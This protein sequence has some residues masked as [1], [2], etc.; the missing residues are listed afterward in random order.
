MKNENLLYFSYQDKIYPTLINRGFQLP[1][2]LPNI[3]PT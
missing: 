1:K 2:M 3:E